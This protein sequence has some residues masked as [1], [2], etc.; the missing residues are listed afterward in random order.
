MYLLL[1]S[2][3]LLLSSVVPAFEAGHGLAQNPFLCP[4]AL[5]NIGLHNTFRAQ[6]DEFYVLMPHI[7]KIAGHNCDK[8]EY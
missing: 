6:E 1:S 5:L 7:A 3:Y 4:V 8:I 2:V